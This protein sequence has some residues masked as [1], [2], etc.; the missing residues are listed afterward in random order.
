M[1][2][3][4]QKRINDVVLRSYMNNSKDI[5]IE[6]HA[7]LKKDFGIDLKFNFEWKKKDFV[8]EML[9]TL[10]SYIGKPIYGW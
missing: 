10:L 1:E 6:D 4:I 2:N 5:S 9:H 8:S 7:A 3:I